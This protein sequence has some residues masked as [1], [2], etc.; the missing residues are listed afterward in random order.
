MNA[1][2]L[3]T[4]VR[5][6][7]RPRPQKIPQGKANL[8]EQAQCNTTHHRKIYLAVELQEMDEREYSVCLGEG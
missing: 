3:Q 5:P 7:Y 4:Q 6:S 2:A 8:I 1:N